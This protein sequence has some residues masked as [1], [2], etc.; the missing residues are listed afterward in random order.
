MRPVKFTDWFVFMYQELVFLGIQM[1][2]QLKFRKKHQPSYLAYN[3]VWFTNCT[4]LE[5]LQAFDQLV[6]Y[7]DHGKTHG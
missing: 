3:V 7:L 5:Q 6:S 1:V 2:E 4:W